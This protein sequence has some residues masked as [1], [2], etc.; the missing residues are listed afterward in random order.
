MNFETKNG[1]YLDL[2]VLYDT[3]L[4]TLELIDAK[5]A[6]LALAKDYFER[7][8]DVFPFLNKQTFKEL[9]K[10]RDQEVLSKAMLTNASS[11]VKN[12]ITDAT[13]KVLTSPYKGEINI[14]LNTYPYQL[15]KQQAKDFAE[16]LSSMSVGVASVYIIRLSPADLTLKYC[17]DNFSL[18]LMYDYEDWLEEHAKNDQFRKTPV[19]DIQLF[20]PELYFS[21]KSHSFEEI[22]QITREVA[23]P[24]R[25]VEQMARPLIDL[26]LIPIINY[27]ANL[28]PHFIEEI[29]KE[30]DTPK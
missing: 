9:Y 5:L 10:D 3:R 20:A 25:A 23:H 30:A 26:T 14:F 28:E 18:M 12:F 21:V 2:D 19:P 16:P 15:T 6:R 11:I 24:F 13:K 27:C 29:R 4:A 7:I 22:K 8:E 1:L 17:K